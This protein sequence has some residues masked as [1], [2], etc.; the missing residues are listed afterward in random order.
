MIREDDERMKEKELE[1]GERMTRM[2]K[3]EKSNDLVFK[4]NERMKMRD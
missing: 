2:F 1:E 4:M 3:K